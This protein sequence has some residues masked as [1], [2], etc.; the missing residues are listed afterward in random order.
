MTVRRSGC[1]LALGLLLAARVLAG[2]PGGARVADAGAP[3]RVA[4]AREGAGFELSAEELAL[5]RELEVLEKFELL[6]T[7]ELFEPDRGPAPK[8]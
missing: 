7:L 1:A 4:E 3:A 2:D 6:Q 5:V 8:P